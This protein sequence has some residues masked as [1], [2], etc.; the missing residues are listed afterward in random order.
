MADPATEPGAGIVRLAWLGTGTVV[1]TSVAAALAPDAFA[2]VHA[3]VSVVLFVAGTAALLWAYALGVGRSRTDLV[4]LP[5][6]FWL[7]GDAAR[8]ST[9]RRLRWAVLVEVMAV[10]AAA[11]VRPFTEVAFGIL[12]PMFGLGMMGMWGGRHGS[13]PPRPSKHAARGNSPSSRA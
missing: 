11:S 6:L 5:G 8:A 9:R 3:G 4:D 10:V 2:V 7:A 1:V 12:A 13:F